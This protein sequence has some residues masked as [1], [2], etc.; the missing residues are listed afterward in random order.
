[1]SLDYD[2][3]VYMEGDG[4]R[5]RR[6]PWVIA[7]TLLALLVGG[8]AAYAWSE[9][10]T[11]SY[12]VPSLVGMTEDEARASVADFGFRVAREDVREDGSTPG[13]VLRTEPESGA[14]LD[15]GATLVL[16]VSIGNE[17]ATVPTDLV[18]LPL[19]EAEEALDSAG[20]FTAA[21]VEA[22]SEDVDAGVVIG[23]RPDVPA[24]LAKGSEVPL[25]VSKG[26][27]P[28]AIPTG[29]EGGTYDEAAA[30][31]QAVQLVPERAEDFSDDVEEGRV[32]ELRPGSGTA[33]RDS[34]VEVVVSKGPDLVAAPSV[35]GKTLDEAVATL[36]SAGFVVG[37]AFG[38]AKGTPFETDPP[39][40]TKVKRGATVDIYL[41]R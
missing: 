2:L 19:A 27:A 38:P 26:P 40:G 33:P 1:V 28:R 34:V 13:T 17:L 7:A 15:E 6:W 36:E 14:Q 22:E 10:R 23:L 39:T 11:P 12:E 31:L 18:G 24:E 21:V 4:R 16:F 25:I 41:R 3:A 20:Q 37:D 8:A 5:P 35:N 32:I 29:L 9:V 30:A